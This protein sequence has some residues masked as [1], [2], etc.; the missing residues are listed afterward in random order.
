MS[1]RALA[2]LKERLEGK[3]VVSVEDSDASEVIAKFT[4]SDG[5]AFRLHA[6]D[7]GYWVEDTVS[8]NGRYRSFEAIFLDVGRHQDGLQPQHDFRAPSPVAEID[9]LV[10]RITTVDGRTF[11]GDMSKFT[12]WERLVCEH[13]RGP[14]LI[15]F[16]SEQ[17][18]MWKTAF[19]S[20]DWDSVD[21]EYRCPAELTLLA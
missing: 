10:L 13:P 19:H 9:G 18:V 16:A 8:G 4:M 7:L 6:T 11:E 21:P 17:G 14:W 2:R 3:T 1:Q 12:D 20:R 15:A 5:T